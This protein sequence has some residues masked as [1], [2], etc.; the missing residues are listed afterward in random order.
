MDKKNIESY[1]TFLLKGEMFAVSVNKVLEIIETGEEHTI[2][3]LPKAAK[4]ISGVVNF[5]GNVIPVIDT[6]IKFDLQSF[7]E[8]EKFVVIVLNLLI[9]DR[10]QM[11]GAMADKVVDVIEI[12]QAEIK[13]VPEVGQGYNSEFIHGVVHRNNKFIMLLNLEEAIGT[14]AITKL[15]LDKNEDITMTNQTKPSEAINNIELS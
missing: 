12:D 2:S 14:E 6:R 10:E 5:R 11:V 9:N 8:K 13:S 3:Y 4:S 15:R 7:Q 1:L